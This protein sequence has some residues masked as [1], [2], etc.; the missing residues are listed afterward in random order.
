MIEVKVHDLTTLR[1]E[2]VVLDIVIDE[3]MSDAE[4]DK[5]IKPHLTQYLKHNNYRILTTTSLL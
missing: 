4:A 1:D 5:I 3:N 2:Y